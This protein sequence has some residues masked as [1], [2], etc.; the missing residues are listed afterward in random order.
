MAVASSLPHMAKNIELWYETPS[1]I[2]H[3]AIM[4]D[5]ADDDSMD[6]DA[7]DIFIMCFNSFK[8]GKRFRVWQDTVQGTKKGLW[9]GY[10]VHQNIVTEHVYL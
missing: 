2:I 3:T 9:V 8:D 6:N 10:K 4:N 7:N 5:S 1:I